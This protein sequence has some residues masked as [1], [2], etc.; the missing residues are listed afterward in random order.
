MKRLLGMAALMALICVTASAQNEKKLSLEEALKTAVER[1]LDIQL[2]RVTVDT[3]QLELQSAREVNYEPV[4]TSNVSTSSIDSEPQ[5]ILQGANLDTITRESSSWNSSLSKNEAFGFGWRINFNNSTSETNSADQFGTFYSSNLT[6]SVQQELLQGFAF[7]REILRNQE[8]IAKSDLNISQYDLEIQV[9]SVLQSTEEAYWDLVAAIE[10]YKVAESNLKLAQQLYEQNKVKVDVGT[11]APIELVSNEATIA[12]RESEII[13][14]EN[15]VRTA[16]DTLKR[17]LN[18]PPNQWR[19]KLIPSDP[20]YVETIE[21]NPDTAFEKALAN[22]PELLK[23]SEQRRKAQ[24]SHKFNQNQLRPQLTFQGSYQSIGAS[25]P[26]A[27]AE[28]GL[29]EDANYIDA[30]NKARFFEFPGWSASLN[31]NWRPF[32][33]QAKINLARSRVDIRRQDLLTEQTQLIIVEEVRGALRELESNAKQ[34]AA[35]ENNVK[36]R[37]ENLKAEEQRFQN[38]LSTNYLVAE[39]QNELADA[40]SRLIQSKIDYLKAVARYYKAMGRLDEERRITVQ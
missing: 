33:K 15:R 38:G 29:V 4:V 31:L 1:N 19:D 12:T 28:A 8:Y 34:I 9:S 3:T 25:S 17:V 26:S 24:L 20:L 13:T 14:A 32:N 10:Q 22:R 11:L 27:T 40:R 35:N 5:N 30:L 6:L 16:E 7:D 39:R 2:Q 37:E 36:F 18:L 23:N 21:P